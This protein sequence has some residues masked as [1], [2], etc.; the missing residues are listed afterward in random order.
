MIYKVLLVSLFSLG[1]CFGCAQKMDA[2]GACGP[3]CTKPCCAKEKAQCPLDCTK[4]CCAKK[5]G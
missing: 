5:P 4:P 1:L 2:K 3:D